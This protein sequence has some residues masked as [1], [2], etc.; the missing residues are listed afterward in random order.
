M[1]KVRAVAV[2]VDG[3]ITDGSMKLSTAA[4]EAIRRLEES[5]VRVMLASHNALCVVKALATY[6]GCTGPIICEGGGVVEYAGRLRRLGSKLV[7]RRA[8][9]RLKEAFD[10]LI[11]ESWSNRFRL[12]D[13]AF[14]SSLD[15]ARLEEALKGVEGVK[16]VYTGFAYHVVDSSVDKGRGLRVASRLVGVKPSEVVAVGDSDVDVDM[17]LSSGLGVA[18]GNATERLKEAA[19]LI[20]D[21]D[22]G[23]GFTK[24]ASMILSGEL[25]R[26]LRPPSRTPP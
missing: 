25:N 5:G 9:A 13:Q 26:A 20:L 12:V 24:L 11:E 21:E 4:V 6:I 19:D 15:R 17:L 1:V 16:L 18:L 3:T 2:D 22:Y 8:L 14:T 23:E 10:G 7:A